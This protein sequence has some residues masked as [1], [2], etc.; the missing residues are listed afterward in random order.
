MI[1][2]KRNMC[3]D[4]IYTAV[5]EA[6]TSCNS[7]EEAERLCELLTKQDLDKWVDVAV[8]DGV[9]EIQLRQINGGIKNGN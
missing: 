2:E 9:I 8:Q 1:N 5:K 3:L 4:K 6:I 7:F